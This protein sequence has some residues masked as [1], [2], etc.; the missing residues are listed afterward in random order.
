[1]HRTAAPA[2]KKHIVA[3]A[4]IAAFASTTA[5]SLDL[6]TAPP[7]T[8][9]PY[10]APNVIISVDDSGS[11][12][13]RVDSEAYTFNDQTVPN[14]DGSWPGSAKRINVLKHALVGSGG[15]GGIFRDTT[16]LP[17]K[18]IRLAWQVMWNNGGAPD[19][20]SVDSSTMKTNSMRPLATTLSLMTS[21]GVDRMS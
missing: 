10:V 15:T 8:I 16:L 4:V 6:S 1:M 12:A 5:W 11:M 3:L 18:K 2:F 7:G 20:A 9:E 17:D 19:A 14:A 21:A 13:F